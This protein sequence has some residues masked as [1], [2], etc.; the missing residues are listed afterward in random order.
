[1]ILCP[2]I[3]A[4]AKD[5]VTSKLRMTEPTKVSMAW[6]RDALSQHLIEL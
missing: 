3:L 6:P 5:G 2:D 1:M 4:E